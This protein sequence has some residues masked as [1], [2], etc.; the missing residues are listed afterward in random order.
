[1]SDWLT[2]LVSVS[3]AVIGAISSINAASTGQRDPTGYDKAVAD[4]IHSSQPFVVT[5]DLQD[6]VW[7]HWTRHRRAYVVVRSVT[8]EGQQMI[9]MTKRLFIE[10]A[11]DGSW[12]VHGEI[13]SEVVPLRW[14]PASQKQPPQSVTRQFEAV[15]VEK[16]GGDRHLVLK[17]KT[18]NVVDT[19][20][21][22]TAYF[23]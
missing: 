5:R 12:C 7:I 3:I 10:P 19:I 14:M 18:G 21:N 22:A 8:A 9:N 4:Y 16:V 23:Q 1:M 13:M 11:R 2:S 20:A 15:S 6:F 17:D